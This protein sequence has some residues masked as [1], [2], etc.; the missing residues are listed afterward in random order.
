MNGMRILGVLLVDR[1]LR[2]VMVVVLQVHNISIIIREVVPSGNRHGRI[3]HR[4]CR[5]LVGLVQMVLVLLLRQE[6]MDKIIIV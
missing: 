2:K 5:R 3:V 1:V 4:W 6:S